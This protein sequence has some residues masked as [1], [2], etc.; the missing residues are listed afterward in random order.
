MNDVEDRAKEIASLVY[1]GP[2]GQ[3]MI[4][5]DIAAALRAADAAGFARGVEMAAT[6]VEDEGKR[7]FAEAQRNFPDGDMVAQTSLLC[8]QEYATL[9]RALKES[10]HG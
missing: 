3:G 9:I 8:S 4:E 1:A 5:R 7:V 2:Y 10:A 6:A